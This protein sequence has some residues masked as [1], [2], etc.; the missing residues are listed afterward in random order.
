[1]NAR[2]IGLFAVLTLV[3]AIVVGLVIRSRH[4]GPTAASSGDGVA[5]PEEKA[6][7]GDSTSET[8]TT[9]AGVAR[10]SAIA[11][12]VTEEPG[13]R[14][15][16]GAS[17][18]AS[19]ESDK[20]ATA[21]T[22]TPYCATT[23]AEGR[24]RIEALPAAKY[25]VNATAAGHAPVRLR[26]DK[27]EYG[28]ALKAGEVQEHVDFALER[29]G[30][31]VK[32]RVKDIA[33][34]TVAN[35]VVTVVSGQE[36][37]PTSTSVAKSGAQGEFTVWVAPGRIAAKAIASGY[38]AGKKT[39]VAPGQLIEILLTPESVLQGKVVEAGTD[40]PVAG[41]KVSA[42]A[43]KQDVFEWGGNEATTFTDAEGRFRIPGLDPGRYKPTAS[44]AH[45]FGT[46]PESVLLGLAESSHEVVIEMHAA[47]AIS[48]KI[49]LGGKP[50]ETG[51]VSLKE[52]A[53]N[54]RRWADSDPEGRVR[55]DGLL[56]GTY[57]VQV[58]CEHAAHRD[59]YD[60]IQLAAKDVTGVV[61]HVDA[62]LSASGIV[63]D[64]AGQPVAFARVQAQTKGGDPRSQFGWASTETK[65]DGTFKL[66]GLL[67]SGYGLTVHREGI[68]P[69]KDPF[70]LKVDR[71]VEGVKITLA[72]GGAIEGTI[73][74]SSGSP[75]GGLGV[76][77]KGERWDWE[78]GQTTSRDDGTFSFPSLNPGDY[79]VEAQRNWTAVRAPGTKDDD[80]QGATATVRPGE[81]ARVKIV[82]ESQR[83]EIRGRVV[84]ENGVALSDAFVDAERE[85]ESAG[86]STG[87][88]R[89]AMHWDWSDR[90]PVLTDLEGNF[91]VGKLS[92]GAYTVRAFRKGGGESVVEGV[93]VGTSVTLKIKTEG[94]IS[95]TLVDA[96]GATPERFS[97][98]LRDD[99]TGVARHES[100]FGTRGAWTMRDLSEGTYHVVGEAGGRALVDVKIAQGEK[101][102]G[103]ALVLEPHA[104]V[105][106]RVIALETG[107]P[108]AGMQVFVRAAKGDQS[109]MFFIDESSDR[110]NITDADGRFELEQAPAGRV[111]VTLFPKD[112]SN[113]DYA[114]ASVGATV[115]A[116]AP[117]EIPPIK[118]ARARVKGELTGDLGFTTRDSEP[119]ADP[120]QSRAVVALVR[121][122]SAVAKA[123]LAV[124]DEIVSVDGYDVVGPNGYLYSALTRVP[125]GTVLKLGLKSGNA[126]SVRADRPRPGAP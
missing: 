124:G 99:R 6:A 105:R 101:R 39:G 110:R 29:G 73:V 35:A 27:H 111:V 22:K 78:S 54:E 10:R 75:V 2:R 58:Y 103:V 121:P 93:R 25:A 31:E 33:G 14:P 84:D 19:A 123:G 23:D 42:G 8:E 62:G 15:I 117:N 90:A 102:E 125:E 46:A 30:V 100:F 87:E 82:V 122:N 5:S 49:D 71:D 11:G 16:A 80:V 81:T 53:T 56:P 24:Y 118:V 57:E 51:N 113:G 94:S 41:A 13:G 97:I 43:L 115:Q 112:F 116:G 86:A 69:L 83:G 91:T 34:G 18:C 68:T 20:L 108:V 55:I 109:N 104:T 126:I 92:P 106:G 63:V 79:H 65:K 4:A 70:D 119:G 64:S 66:R 26:G 45:G 37:S 40:N 60:P 21:D 38:T 12:R 74:D 36:W 98:S 85:P 76:R 89:R 114:F 17:V 1:M 88:A 28:L 50:C 61:W 7:S 120:D 67:N 95:G 32:G 72:S 3:C 9:G 96:K 107:K 59:K 52:K 48:G 44:N 77:A 47:L